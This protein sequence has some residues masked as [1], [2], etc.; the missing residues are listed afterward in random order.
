MFNLSRDFIMLSLRIY[1]DLYEQTA[2]ISE[3][4]TAHTRPV[5]AWATCPKILSS[6]HW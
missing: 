5:P 4:L 3:A 1:Y 2:L 6:T